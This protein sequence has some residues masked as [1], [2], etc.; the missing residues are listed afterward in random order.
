MNPSVSDGW[1]ERLQCVSIQLNSQTLG[2]LDLLLLSQLC[3]LL[4][5]LDLCMP[6]N[7]LSKRRWGEI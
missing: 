5:I 3:F 7:I 4:V 1:E 6:A 2:S